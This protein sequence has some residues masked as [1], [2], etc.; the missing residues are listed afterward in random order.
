MN[1]PCDAAPAAKGTL[2]DLFG[3]DDDSESS[4]G[5]K[6]YTI[7]QQNGDSTRHENEHENQLPCFQ[8]RKR[9][10]PNATNENEFIKCNK[11]NTTTNKDSWEQKIGIFDNVLT[12]DECDEL[13]AIHAS[14]AHAGYIDHLQ[15]T[16]VSDF[17]AGN[18]TTNSLA[19]VLPLLRARYKMWETVEEFYPE[20]SLEIFPEYTALSAWHKG[21]FLRMHYDSN[22]DYLLDRHYSALLY[23]NDSS[24]TDD[25][26][27][28]LHH[29]SNYHRSGFSGG[30]LVFE[31]PSLAA[32]TTLHNQQT[33]H[34][35]LK[36]IQPR[37]GRLVCFPSS[38]DY[39]HGVEEIKRGTRFALTM[40]FTK[41]PSA[42][43]A[44][45]SLQQT[46][47]SH[48]G[49]KHPNTTASKALSRLALQQPWETQGQAEA[50]GCR[51]LER[52]GFNIPP[53]LDSNQGAATAT[54]DYSIT[55][56]QPELLQLIAFCWWKKGVPLGDWVSSATKTTNVEKTHSESV[57]EVGSE[58]ESN[59]TSIHWK[60]IGGPPFRS[61]FENWREDYLPKRW[62][63]L[64]SAMDRWMNHDGGLITSVRDDELE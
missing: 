39:V 12:Q 2:R 9:K 52:A 6:N 30:D 62:R 38:S 32:T 47:V 42:M 11:T 16:R 53:P 45:A 60:V 13:I 55:M 64:S 43:E 1:E 20:A 49:F 40:W 3:E 7:V 28:T 41:H 44:L 25:H 23:L 19:M 14:H 57:Q 31:V 48:P 46:Y 36:R 27:H 18:G 24:A 63:G 34:S 51:I 15:V 17:V 21:A 56:T 22:K 10:A 58:G 5:S 33:S 26:H 54:N 8:T 59:P 61:I 4:N 29:P 37:A 50:I 35:T